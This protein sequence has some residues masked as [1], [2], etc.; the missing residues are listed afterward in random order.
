MVYIKTRITED[1][2]NELRVKGEQALKDYGFEYLYSK[3][4]IS[5]DKEYKGCFLHRNESQYEIVF[6]TEKYT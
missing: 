6:K 2:Y 3:G 1:I 5:S 4:Y